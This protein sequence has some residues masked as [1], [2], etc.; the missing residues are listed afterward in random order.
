[1]MFRRYRTARAIA[2][3]DFPAAVGPQMMRSSAPAEASLELIPADLD[4]ST[5]PMHVVRG[6]R[7]ARERDVERAHLR[8]RERVSRLDRRLARDGRREALVPRETTAEAVA[9]QRCQRVA[10]AS[11]RIEPLV[12]HRHA[13]DEQCVPSESL[14]LETETREQV[15]MLLESLGLRRGE[16]EGHRK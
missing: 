4:D 2:S 12:R 7:R 14:D 15:A 9:G 10:Q 8:W 1:M 6:E 13:V 5:P 16:V 11:F 3:A